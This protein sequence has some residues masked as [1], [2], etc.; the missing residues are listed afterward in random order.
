MGFANSP[1]SLHVNQLLT[2]FTQKRMN[3]D[4]QFIYPKVVTVSP[5]DKLA[6]TYAVYDQ[7][8]LVRHT[9][10]RAPGGPK[11]LIDEKFT[12]STYTMKQIEAAVKI[13]EESVENA[14]PAVRPD[15]SAASIVSQQMQIRRETDAASLIFT[16]GNYNDQT[17]T[18][19]HVATLGGSRL[20][21]S[22]TNSINALSPIRQIMSAMRTVT[23]AVLGD[24]GEFVLVLGDQAWEVLVNHPSVLARIE[25]VRPTGADVMWQ[26]STL[27]SI[28]GVK[29]VLIGLSGYNSAVEGATTV[30]SRLWTGTKAALVLA[31]QTIARETEAFGVMFRHKDYPKVKRYTDD[32]VDSD[33]V[34]EK[35]YY[36]FQSTNTSAGFLWD[37]AVS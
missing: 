16:K 8:H 18:A 20:W 31:P 19:G 29:A 15:V 9:L 34:D 24:Y 1:H 26:G 35:D 27:A 13:A 25:N 22:Y 37:T 6:D 7:T 2:D 33:I 17:G 12:T 23:T 14:D 5:R 36:V 10:D 28:L 21:S 32:T 30:M 11:N 4:K 3:A